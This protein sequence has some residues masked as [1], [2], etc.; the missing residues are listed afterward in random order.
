MD[1]VVKPNK[2]VER[3]TRM[4]EKIL[5]ATLDCIY[6]YGFNQ[7]STT[8]IV[9]RAKVSR[10][11]MLHHYPVKET[12]IA[13]AVGKLLEDEIADLRKI[14][15]AYAEGHKTIDD[16]VDYLWERFSGRLFMITIDFLS[17]SRTDEKLREALIP[18]S[19]NFHDSLNEIWLQFFNHQKKSP[20][21]IRLLLNTTLC[22][23]RGMGA[24]TIIRKDKAY[25]DEIIENWKSLLHSLLD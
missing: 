23:L 21:E 3:S 22:L 1:A 10:G 9:K 2:H 6:E 13:A 14:A 11:A 12:L 7:A 18:V 25:F 8:E 19:L 24:Q 20:E 16:F 15:A 4:K 5:K 17:N